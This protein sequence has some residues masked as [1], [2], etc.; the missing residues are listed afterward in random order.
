MIGYLAVIRSYVPRN[1]LRSTE[2]KPNFELSS[3]PCAISIPVH[4][5][6]GKFKHSCKDT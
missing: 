5:D 2:H 1:S 4:D 6:T 3:F